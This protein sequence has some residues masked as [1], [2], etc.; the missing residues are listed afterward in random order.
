MAQWKTL[1][2]IVARKSNLW[3]RVCGE[4]NVL[5]VPTEHK[6]WLQE[7]NLHALLFS[8][9]LEIR[10]SAPF[11]PVQWKRIPGVEKRLW[12]ALEIS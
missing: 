7:C 12:A 9:C 8:C 10:A 11:Q 5:A 4:R 1:V 3:K 2:V 6:G